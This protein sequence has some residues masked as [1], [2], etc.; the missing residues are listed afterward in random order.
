MLGL[1]LAI[2]LWALAPA[3]TRPTR[4]EP[5]PEPGEG[6]SSDAGTGS[7]CVEPNP[8]FGALPDTGAWSACSSCAC[9]EPDFTVLHQWAWQ[10]PR[11]FVVFPDGALFAVGTYYSPTSV[12][13]GSGPVTYM[14][15][16]GFHPDRLPVSCGYKIAGVVTGSAG[17]DVVRRADGTL[18][19]AGYLDAEMR[20]W[21]SSEPYYGLLASYRTENGGVDVFG[22]EPTAEGSVLVGFNAYSG[23]P[24]KAPV[25]R[26]H[27]YLPDGTL[28][29]AFGTGGVVQ[30]PGGGQ[31]KGTA[32]TRLPDG[33]LVVVGSGS[34]GS[35]V[36]RLLPDGQLDSTF[37]GGIVPI[38][39]CTD[40]VPLE[41]GRLLLGGEFSNGASNGAQF[42]RLQSDGTL[43][44]TFGCGGRLRIPFSGV[45]LI[46]FWVR[47]E[48][49]LLMLTSRA[50]LQVRPDGTPDPDF[51]EAG[52]IPLR[53]R[54]TVGKLAPDGSLV[55]LGTVLEQAMANNYVTDFAMQRIRLP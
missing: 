1:V 29:T 49:R 37:S 32:L 31:R 26:V 28:D 40:V 17:T 34:D 11:D 53:L 45:P 14:I 50:V 23:S 27:R 9:V 4:P 18:I 12:P 35:F 25:M 48:G 33:K 30:Y 52:Q 24:G 15:T 46:D 39:C 36:M 5:E 38:D 3:C 2:G 10:T 51:G 41:D 16:W 54:A 22:L 7:T 20:L 6:G 55:V 21:K 44:P 43:D 47:P 19:I 8:G 42:L 13:A